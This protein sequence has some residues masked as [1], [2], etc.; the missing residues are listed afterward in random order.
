MKNL[1]DFTNTDM[2]NFESILSHMIQEVEENNKKV[3]YL[4]QENDQL[5]ID[6]TRFKV[7]EESCKKVFEEN[8]RLKQE[9]GEKQKLGLSEKDLADIMINAKRVANDIIRKSKD[10]ALKI[11]QQNQEMLRKILQMGSLIEE[12]IIKFKNKFDQDFN[13]WC[14]NLNSFKEVS[15]INSSPDDLIVGKIK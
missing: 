3:L 9:L 5:R 14:Q 13:Q 6:N 7:N 12:D 10:D 11:E 4:I 2:K 1:N 8:N 15:K